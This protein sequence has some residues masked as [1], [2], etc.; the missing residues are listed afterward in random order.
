MEPAGSHPGAIDYWI[1]DDSAM[2]RAYLIVNSQEALGGRFL[3]GNPFDQVT[4]HMPVVSISFTPAN[5]KEV[6]LYPFNDWSP[7]KIVGVMV[8][9]IPLFDSHSFSWITFDEGRKLNT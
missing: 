2:L 1:S 5:T 7:R 9:E 6:T 4:H 8:D 3:E